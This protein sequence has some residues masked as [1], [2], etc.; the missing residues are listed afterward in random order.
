MK[1]KLTTR[2]VVLILLAQLSFSCSE[3]F[4]KYTA[5]LKKPKYRL[6][7][8]LNQN[9][10][11]P[12]R[13]LESEWHPLKIHYDISGLNSVKQ[14]KPETYSLIV[15]ELMPSVL[16]HLT[17]MLQVQGEQKLTFQETPGE[18]LVCSDFPIPP[19][20][21]NKEIQADLILF[22]TEDPEISQDT[23]VLAWASPCY[24]D[25][26]TLRPTVGRIGF[27]TY[28]TNL[29]FFHFRDHYGTIIHEIMHI[30]G[31]HEALYE[32]FYDP[33]TGKTKTL[34]ETLTN[35]GGSAYPNRII[36]PKVV[37][38]GREHYGCSTLNGVPLENVGEGSA[39]SH[40]EKTTALSEFMMADMGPNVIISK[41]TL[42]LLE[43][44]GWYKVNYNYAEPFFYG[45]NRGCQF[46]ETNECHYY[47]KT[48]T[49]TATEGTSCFFDYTSRAY[50]DADYYIDD[51]QLFSFSDMKTHDCRREE[52]RDESSASIKEEFGDG[53]RCI[54]TNISIGGSVISN[55]C[56]K[57]T[58][59][60]LNQ[61]VITIGGIEYIC[62]SSGQILNPTGIQGT[63]KCPNL[64]DFC[65]Y[66]NAKC[67]KEC[68]LNGRCLSGNKCYCYK[69]YFGDGCEKHVD[70]TDDENN[71]NN[72]G[73]TNTEICDPQCIAGTCVK[74]EV[75]TGNYCSCFRGYEGET[76]NDEVA[77][78][79]EDKKFIGVIA[80]N[81]VFVILSLFGI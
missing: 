71:N 76:C 51:C 42:A 49:D 33:V 6:R 29:D 69:G 23:S 2:I 44:S 34:E 60:E 57:S 36:S 70:D 80:I 10:G 16:Q 65:D 25:D 39:G 22:L 74:N 79:P 45:K 78:I 1:L 12:R 62:M 50:C 7:K 73:D 26:N 9:I 53:S 41:L 68:S 18:E 30:L 37:E 66:D 72:G 55:S 77:P 28:V 67:P 13:I 64:E 17:D 8:T 4:R 20:L 21:I 32:F 19:E 81:G 40:W 54:E 47:G 63:V 11:A 59:N 58:C 3:K 24:L 43:D 35:S 61:V 14:S 48:C 56:Y 27:N 75:G 38:F 46:F 15:N 5:E 31:F 52:T